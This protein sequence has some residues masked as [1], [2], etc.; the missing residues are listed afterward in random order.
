[1][2]ENR[3]AQEDEAL[4]LESIYP[5]LTHTPPTAEDPIRTYSFQ[6]LY[7][8]HADQ[9]LTIRFYVSPNYPSTD[10]PVFEI[11]SEWFDKRGGIVSLGSEMTMKIHDKLNALWEE[12]RKGDVVIYEFVEF[13]KNEVQDYFDEHRKQ[14]EEDVNNELDDGEEGQEVLEY[15]EYEWDPEQYKQHYE[16]FKKDNNNKDKSQTHNTTNPEDDCPEIFSSTEPLIDRKSVFVAHLARVNS[17]ED[18]QKVMERLLSN[19]KIARA[20]HNMSAYRIQLPNGVILA[21]CDD[22]GENGA[23]GNMAHL[24]QIVNAKNV[25]VVVSR[26]YG[27]I[28]LGGDRFRHINNVARDLLTAHGC[29]ESKGGKKGK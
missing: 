14:V 5:E 26:W 13:V 7:K 28:K 9:S 21:D 4:A 6:F 2:D 10:C 3:I 11:V 15:E 25:L 16:S 27:G 20:T 18:V 29:T 23:G 24:L 22:D 17:K 1:M 19:S 12:E 8:D